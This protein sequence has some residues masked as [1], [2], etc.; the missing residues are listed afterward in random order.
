MPNSL[1]TSPVVLQTT[2]T[3]YKA[4]T[5][6]TLG[7]LTSIRIERVY[8]EAPKNVGDVILITDPASGRTIIRLQ[9]ATANLG[10]D[11]DWTANPKLVSDFAVPQMDSG[12]LY[13]HLR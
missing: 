5:S 3:S 1:N 8:W 11:M 7:A 4:A 12:N 10:I 6:T 13:I 9:C 2:Q